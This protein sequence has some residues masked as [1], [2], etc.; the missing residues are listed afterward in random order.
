VDNM[1]ASLRP[2]IE[3]AETADVLIERIDRVV[4]R[5]LQ[6]GSTKVFFSLEVLVNCASPRGAVPPQLFALIRRSVQAEPRTAVSWLRFPLFSESSG[7]DTRRPTLE[8]LADL[9]IREL[10]DPNDLR[11]LL[12]HGMKRAEGLAFTQWFQ[13]R[14]E[15]ERG[16]D[17]W[18][19]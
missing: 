15:Q 10:K 14:L 12:W 13:Q 1:V 4:S 8:A 9:L 3:A 7:R 18:R 19:G 5:I 11:S 17:D 2:W 6:P 16:I